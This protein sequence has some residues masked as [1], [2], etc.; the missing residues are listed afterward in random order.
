VRFFGFAYFEGSHVGDTAMRLHGFQLVQ[1]PV[2]LV[3][4]IHG[5]ANVAVI[6]GG[7]GSLDFTLLR[8]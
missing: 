2:E 1:A 4:G 8:G 7:D 3:D 6:A 5:E